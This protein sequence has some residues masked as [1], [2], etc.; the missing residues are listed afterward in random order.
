MQ[1]L[2]D[3]QFSVA[4]IG[5]EKWWAQT[6]SC[7]PPFL[8]VGE[9]AGAPAAPFLIRPWFQYTLNKYKFYTCIATHIH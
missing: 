2:S 3:S 4:Y 5:D 9:G 6:H 8:N 7:P 1:I